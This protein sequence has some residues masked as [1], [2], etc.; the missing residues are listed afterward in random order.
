M[1]KKYKLFIGPAEGTVTGQSTAFLYLKNYFSHE[2]FINTNFQDL[3][4]T[5]KVFLT[6]KTIF[7]FLN[8]MFKND[9]GM[10]YISISRSFL[11]SIKDLI[12]I[13][14]S[15][16][17]SCQKIVLHLHGNDLLSFRKNSFF[18][19]RLLFD[20]SYKKAT[21]VIVS[22]ENMKEQFSFIANNVSIHSVVNCYSKD[23]NVSYKKKEFNELRLLYLSNLMASKGIFELLE[24]CK[25]LERKN[26]NFKLKVAGVELSDHLMSKDEVLKKLKSYHSLKNVD[27]LGLVVG[28]DKIN[29]LEW[30]NIFI[31]PTRYPTEA[32]PIS[33]IEAM[34]TGSIIIVTNHNGLDKIIKNSVHYIIKSPIKENIVK[35]IGDI[36]HK[37]LSEGSRFNM[38]HAKKKYNLESHLSQ[39]CK[40]FES[41]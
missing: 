31:L 38:N 27:F 30:A 8:R 11:G 17:F 16:L 32:F 37:S 15:S 23:I 29:I 25:E 24:A 9:V 41:S 36:N 20:Y 33:I 10:V 40:I 34:A 1:K 21:D 14:V 6:L 2:L 18:L 28:K 35:I 19:Y 12:I 22:H 7:K 26:I 4:K 3:P 13:N 5:K 39:L